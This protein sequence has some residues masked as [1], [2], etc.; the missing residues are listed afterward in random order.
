MQTKKDIAEERLLI[1]QQLRGAPIQCQQD[2]LDF[3]LN[4]LP[5]VEIGKKSPRIR[6]LHTDVRHH[7]VILN[8]LKRDVGVAYLSRDISQYKTLSRAVATA[9]K[10]F[11]T[12][13]VR[14]CPEFDDIGYDQWFL[15]TSSAIQE[16]FNDLNLLILE[17]RQDVFQE[18]FDGMSIHDDS[19]S[20]T[21]RDHIVRQREV[22]G[23]PDPN[24]PPPSI[25]NG[26]NVPRTPPASS[27]LFITDPRLLQTPSDQNQDQELQELDEIIVVSSPVQAQAPRTVAASTAPLVTVVADVHRPP[28]S[29]RSSGNGQAMVAI[30]EDT[31]RHTQA[32][33]E[34]QNAHIQR[35]SAELL[36][37]R[38]RSS[39]NARFQIIGERTLP[40]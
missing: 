37:L 35:D 7:L 4:A 25:G 36:R 2:W 20:T 21:I 5:S 16:Q 22:L 15:R 14:L 13:M 32:L 18:N 33:L 26:N 27:S 12:T 11:K 39:S 34:K 1:D 28:L 31:Y 38:Q 29:V 9:T 3:G 8:G 17:L 23:P 40:D 24:R 10:Q 19:F 30:P 6:M